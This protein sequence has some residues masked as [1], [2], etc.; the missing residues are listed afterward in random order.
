MKLEFWEFFAHEAI[1]QNI[2]A[3]TM[4]FA[5]ERLDLLNRPVLIVE[6]GTSNST[7]DMPSTFIFQKYIE[8]Q[9]GGKFFTVDNDK[10]A[11]DFAIQFANPDLMNVFNSDSIIFLSRFADFMPNEFNKI[12]LLY[13]D[14]YHVDLNNPHASALHHLM[15][16]ISAFPFID[17]NTM[18]LID[19]SPLRIHALN[20]FREDLCYIDEP[21]ISGKGM[22][23]AEYANKVGAKFL[24]HNYQLLL[25]GLKYNGSVSNPLIP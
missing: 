6:T 25:T 22:Y 12:D 5:L 24:A 19:D 11:S 21:K 3:I 14:S 18:V 7:K 8:L 4:R 1:H 15:E 9:S 10:E 2:R 20:D 23:I 16:L 17:E 13:L